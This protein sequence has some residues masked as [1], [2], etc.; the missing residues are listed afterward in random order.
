MCSQNQPLRHW[1]VWIEE[2]LFHLAEVRRLESKTSQLHLNKEAKVGSFMQLG[3]KREEASGNWRGNL[4]SVSENTW[5]SQTSGRQ[6]L[7]I[8]SLRSFISSATQTHKFSLWPWSYPLLPDQETV[9][10]HLK[11]ISWERVVL[12]REQ[13]V[14]MCE[15]TRPNQNLNC[16][17]PVA[18]MVEGT[19]ITRGPDTQVY[20]SVN[21]DFL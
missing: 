21:M 14:N 2:G 6:Q 8:S 13:A 7:V 4:S 12:G 20:I 15:P 19:K 9:L 5:C 1:C 18:K 3:G 10:Q 16:L 11:L 17:I